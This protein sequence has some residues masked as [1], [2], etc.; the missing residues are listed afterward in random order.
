VALA[1]EMAAAR[2]P[3]LGVPGLLARLD[4]RFRVLT[5]GRRTALPRQRTL[6]ATLDWSHSLLKPAEAAVFRRLAV[7]AGGCTMEAACGIVSDENVSAASVED[8][9]ASLVSKSLV[10]IDRGAEALRYRMLETMRAY[11]QQKLLEAGETQALQ[12]RHAEYFS[13][14]FE[15]ALGLRLDLK[16]E[17]IQPARVEVGNLVAALEWGFGPSGEVGLACELAA[18]G[19]TM[20]DDRER[21]EDTVYWTDRAL[22]ASPDIPVHLRMRLVAERS[23]ASLLTGALDPQVLLASEQVVVAG[24][25]RQA[26]ALTLLTMVLID[27]FL[28]RGLDRDAVRQ[29]FRQLDVRQG[30]FVLD[31]SE[32]IRISSMDPLDPQLLRK[33]TDALVRTA[34]MT[35]ASFWAIMAI[36]WGSGSDVPWDDSPD[37][38]I[39]AARRMLLALLDGDGRSTDLNPVRQLHHRFIAALCERNAPGDLDEARALAQ[40]GLKTF[41]IGIGDRFN[42]LAMMAWASGRPADT[43]RLLGWT[44]RLGSFSTPRHQ[45]SL[46]RVSS[47]MS[48]ADF[49][50]AMAEGASLTPQQAFDLAMGPSSVEGAARG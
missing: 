4:D 47:V 20:F 43:A 32:I 49:D 15:P 14:F 31:C 13:A 24:S 50:R 16:F 48:R 29:E 22:S 46:V 28:P 38:A 40:R 44:S 2:A 5:A 45:S 27:T 9:L 30:E 34:R 7:F 18:H 23:Y 12:R 42:H 35:G 17:E 33:E 3:T 25:D 36:S 1:I 11:A 19:S 26:R 41:P 39:D 6:Q 10:V 37:M 21:Y 8:A